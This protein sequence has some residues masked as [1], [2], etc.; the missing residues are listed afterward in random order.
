MEELVINN[1]SS[2]EGKDEEYINYFIKE[3]YQ[4]K[5]LYRFC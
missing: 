4:I 1:F 5:K 2:R 3:I